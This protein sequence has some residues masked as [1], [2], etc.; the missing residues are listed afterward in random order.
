M[1]ANPN[2]FQPTLLPPSLYSGEVSHH[3]HDSGE[4]DNSS[5]CHTINL[6]SLSICQ[7]TVSSVS[8]TDIMTSPSICQSPESSV[9]H[10]IDMA[11]PSICQS[12]DMSVHYTNIIT[13]PSICRS[14]ISSACHT[15]NMYG[16]YVITENPNVM[17]RENHN[18][19][20]SEYIIICQDGLYIV[21]TTPEEIYIC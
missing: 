19:Q 4:S 5:V 10:T 16:F 18:T 11:S 13:S 9:C 8:P 21:S 15:I 17:M 7:S 2:I 6:T 14:Y 20:S 12:H 3:M 1:Y